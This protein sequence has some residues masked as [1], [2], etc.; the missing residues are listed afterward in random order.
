MLAV[1]AF[2]KAGGRNNAAGRFVFVLFVQFGVVGVYTEIVFMGF[3]TGIRLL[4][5]QS[6][7]GRPD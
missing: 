2:H 5:V 6:P 4:Q 1:L 7:N 3:Q